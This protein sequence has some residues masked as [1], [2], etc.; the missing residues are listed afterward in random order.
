MRIGRQFGNITL[1]SCE[2]GTQSNAGLGFP[3]ILLK[4]TG[5]AVQDLAEDEAEN[6]I[7]KCISWSWSCQRA[8]NFFTMWYRKP[9]CFHVVSNDV[10]QSLRGI[11]LLQGCP[12]IQ[13]MQ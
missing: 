4:G 5:D 11:G 9:L 1:Q 13:L 10:L 8:N 6:E 3:P 2:A 7:S 12:T